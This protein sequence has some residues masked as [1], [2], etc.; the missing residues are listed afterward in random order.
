MQTKIFIGIAE[1]KKII[2]LEFSKFDGHF[3]DRNVS[4][5]NR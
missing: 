1:K 5:I 2:V 3:I 4:R